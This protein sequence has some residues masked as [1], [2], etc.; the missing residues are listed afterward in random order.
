LPPGIDALIGPGVYETAVHAN[1]VDVASLARSMML[2]LK[3][4]ISSL[5][6]IF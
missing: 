4:I 2:L 1:I 5:K 3:A 6:K